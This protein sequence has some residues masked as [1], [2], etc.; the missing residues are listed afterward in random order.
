MSGIQTAKGHRHFK[1][2]GFYVHDEGEANAISQQYGLKS[3]RKDVWVHEDP[4]GEWSLHNGGETD[5][6]NLTIH[7][8]TFQGV[9]KDAKGGN[10]RVKVKTTDGYTFVSL[11]VALEDGLEIISEKRERRRKRAEVKNGS[12]S[13]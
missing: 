8:Y 5:G 10:D 12:N 6:H 11:A 4:V 3:K 7:R 1:R 9:D 13:K 2:G